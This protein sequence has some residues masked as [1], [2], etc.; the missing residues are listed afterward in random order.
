M[1]YSSQSSGHWSYGKDS[2]LHYENDK[3]DTKYLRIEDLVKAYASFTRIKANLTLVETQTCS[4]NNVSND[5]QLTSE[6]LKSNHDAIVKRYNNF[7]TDCVTAIN[8]TK[9]LFEEYGRFYG[10]DK[11][12]T[13]DK[14]LKFFLPPER[15]HSSKY[16]FLKS[17][18]YNESKEFCFK[19]I[20]DKFKAFCLACKKLI[21]D[22][23]QE[24]IFG[25][26]L[27]EYFL[28]Y[29]SAYI[30][31]YSEKWGVFAYNKTLGDPNDGKPPQ[32]QL[33]LDGI[34][35]GTNRA[36]KK[37]VSTTTSTLQDMVTF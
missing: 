8:E 27:H 20:V 33:I 25:R 17:F 16:N 26:R 13:L 23:P 4:F 18:V 9:V 32:K 22:N 30:F 28:D 10:A 14:G 15:F 1:D 2:Y 35:I 24:T 7:V 6:N 31:A 5:L 34:K 36:S 37:K 29:I 3:N 21:E 11:Y 19:K 12:E